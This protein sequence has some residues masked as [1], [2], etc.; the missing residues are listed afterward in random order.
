MT[1]LGQRVYERLPVWGQNLCCCLYGL[2]LQRGRYG[3]GYAQI[4][5]LAFAADKWGRDR[6]QAFQL[7]RLR[8]IVAYAS[9]HVPYYRELFKSVGLT[10]DDIQRPEDIRAIPLLSKQTVRERLSEFISDEL[11]ALNVRTIS[12]SGTTGT[13][14]RFPITLEA[15]RWQW[16]VLWRF[17][18]RFGMDNTMWY[19]HFFGRSMVPFSQR[20]PPF[21]RINRPGKQVFFS[22]YHV[23]DRNLPTY[24]RELDRRQPAWIQGYPSL[25]T[26]VARYIMET[27]DGLRYVPRFVATSS[28]TLLDHQKEVIARAFGTP[29]RQWYSQ[30]EAVASITECPEGRLHVDEDFG[31]VELVPDADGTYELITTGFYNFAF[32][33]IRYE[34]GDI[35][36][37]PHRESVCPCGCPGRVVTSID[38]RVEDYILTPDG[39]RIGRMDHVFKGMT[40][41]REAQLVQ[42]QVDTILIRIVAGSGFAQR[43]ERK[44]EV[45]VQSRVGADMKVQFTRVGAIERTRHGKLRFVV[46]ELEAGRTLPPDT[47]VCSS[48]GA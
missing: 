39:R 45:A 30:T 23:K 34:T 28:E 10:A 31:Y 32:P 48:S 37:L 47:V 33:L 7:E 41:V 21:W 35:V 9:R 13:G 27:G 17:R 46:S 40:T 4:Q 15:E 1:M 26:L 42:K 25:L 24:V 38:G 11:A 14:L 18:R 44:I 16:A 12:T 5:D 36:A 29:C 3:A 43:D 6:V 19:A 20:H 2:R 22:A 8:A